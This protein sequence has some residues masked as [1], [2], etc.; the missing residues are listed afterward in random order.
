[1]SIIKFKCGRQGQ[2]KNPGI[3][4]KSK[5][6][7]ETKP[8][9]TPNRRPNK[10][11]STRFATEWETEMA[12]VLKREKQLQVLHMLVEGSSL[13]S[14]ERVTGVQKKTVAKLLVKFG[15]ACREFLDQQMRGLELYHLECDEQWTFVLKKQGRIKP[16]DV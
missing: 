2:K 11:D 5:P 1:M 12:N 7:R 8:G 6:G 3:D 16:Q 9:E 4:G 15:N 13:R 10:H 14:I